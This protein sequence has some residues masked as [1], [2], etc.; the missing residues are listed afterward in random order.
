MRIKVKFWIM[1]P[2]NYQLCFL[3]LE[4]NGWRFCIEKLFYSEENG[5]AFW[6]MQELHYARICALQSGERW[7]WQRWCVRSSVKPSCSISSLPFGKTV[8]QLSRRGCTAKS[9]LC[10]VLRLHCSAIL[11]LPV[12][13]CCVSQKSLNH[14]IVWGKWDLEDSL[15]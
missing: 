10:L 13:A 1:A 11:W 9:W 15:P 8:A 14:K 2:S 12:S 6:K 7:K 5:T 3:F 4:G